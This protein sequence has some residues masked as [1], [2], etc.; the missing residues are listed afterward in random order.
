VLGFDFRNPYA[1]HRQKAFLVE[2]IVPSKYEQQLRTIKTWDDW[3]P[4][5]DVYD[6]EWT[7][8]AEHESVNYADGQA[9][10]NPQQ[11]DTSMEKR[12]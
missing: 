2:G 6:Y 5:R 1:L 3:D 11:G 12:Q 9:V 8:F 10:L 7:D 4:N